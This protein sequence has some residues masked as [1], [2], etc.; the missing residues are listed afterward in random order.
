MGKGVLVIGAALSGGL[1]YL[2][3]RSEKGPGEH[4]VGDVCLARFGPLGAGLTWSEVVYNP[5][6]ER[7]GL[8]NLPY[9]AAGRLLQEM[10]DR[11][12][13]PVGGPTAELGRGK[14]RRWGIVHGFATDVVQGQ[15]PGAC[16]LH[17]HG[18][19]KALDV[20][21]DGMSSAEILTELRRSGVPFT[22]AIV[23]PGN[24]GATYLHVE[25][26]AMNP[27]RTGLVYLPGGMLVPADG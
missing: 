12:L 7:L 4:L 10:A 5:A 19:G 9:T 22:R 6:A 14:A 27:G 25:Y 16:P 8:S 20:R 1:L 24:D 13:A 26:D 2:L 11:V 15:T 18:S 23:V 17:G 21:I 3:S